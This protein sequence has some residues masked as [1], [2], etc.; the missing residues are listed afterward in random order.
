MGNVACCGSDRK[1]DEPS[2]MDQSLFNSSRMGRSIVSDH[3]HRASRSCRNVAI[4]DR[5]RIRV[6]KEQALVPS[7]MLL[8]WERSQSFVSNVS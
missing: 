4:D 3:S 1:G 7:D 8:P 2:M 5:C 6:V